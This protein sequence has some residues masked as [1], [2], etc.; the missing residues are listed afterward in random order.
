MTR[1]LPPLNGLRAFEAAARYLSFTKAAEELHV[2]PAAISQ[3]V[4]M[5]EDYF[6]VQLFKRLTRALLLTDSGQRVLP[7]LQEGFDR[8]AEADQILRSQEDEKILTV[9]VAPSFGAKWLVPRLNGFRRVHPDYDIRI[10]AT[11]QKVDFKRDSIDIA[12][13]Y[14]GGDYPGLV[15]DHLLPEFAVPVCS[16][17]LQQGE[18]PLIKPEDLQYHTLLHIQWKIENEAAPNWRMWLRAAGL[19][20]IDADRGLIFSMESM[21]AQAAIE[22][23][24]VA[25]IA[26]ALIADD[27]KSG[28]LIRPFPDEVNQQTQFCYYLVYP[29]SHLQRPK[30]IAFKNWV[31]KEIKSTKI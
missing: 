20:H 22:G 16:P 5:L 21:A 31:E 29:E 6:G 30:V 4:K 13:R 11:D 19:E 24:G 2:T 12:L 3:Q 27:L 15:A 8:L 10:D 7:I 18:H 26:S 1:R 9:S 28:R 23:Q 14:G 17:K 25:L